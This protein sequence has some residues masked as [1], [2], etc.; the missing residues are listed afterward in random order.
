M[1][2]HVEYAGVT[3]FYTGGTITKKLIGLEGR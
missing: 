1:E 2:F 3:L